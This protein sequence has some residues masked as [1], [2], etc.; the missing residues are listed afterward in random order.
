MVGWFHFFFP[1]RLWGRIACWSSH[2]ISSKLRSRRFYSKS[3]VGGRVGVNRG[4]VFRSLVIWNWWRDCI[5]MG[6]TRPLK[7][8]TLDANVALLQQHQ[9][10]CC[11][12]GSKYRN[13]KHMLWRSSSSSSSSQKRKNSLSFVCGL[14]LFALGL[15]S[16][17]TGHVASD[18]EWYSQQ[19]VKRS[20][21]S[22]LVR[23]FPLLSSII[24]RWE[25]F[26]FIYCCTSW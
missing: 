1:F 26:Y 24:C 20:F 7:Y 16:L 4:N 2:F 11:S 25:W 17:L 3:G 18:L 5:V 10:H 13:G 15:I 23:T 21:Y 6:V 19:L 9:Q 8:N 12:N 22:K 14:M